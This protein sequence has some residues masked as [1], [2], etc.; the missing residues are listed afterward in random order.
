MSHVDF[1]GSVLP[2][3]VMAAPSISYGRVQAPAHT[4]LRKT[5][6]RSREPAR[7]ECRCSSLS[8]KSDVK[9]FHSWIF[10][11]DVSPLMRLGFLDVNLSI[12]T[13]MGKRQFLKYTSACNRDIQ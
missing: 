1:L 12:N 6:T 3:P 4:V 5:T 10:H 8:Y 2:E 9:Y 11:D 13:L 7:E